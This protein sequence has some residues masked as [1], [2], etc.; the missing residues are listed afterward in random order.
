MFTSRKHILYTVEVSILERWKI[1]EF[2][3]YE[4]INYLGFDS[5]QK[6]KKKEKKMCPINLSVSTQ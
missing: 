4:H 3:I 6:N 1:I 5:K 2:A